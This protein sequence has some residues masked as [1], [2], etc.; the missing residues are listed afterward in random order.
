MGQVSTYGIGPISAPS[1]VDLSG[2][3][4]VTP[5]GPNDPLTEN[6]LGVASNLTVHTPYGEFTVESNDGIPGFFLP[7]LHVSNGQ[8]Y[9]QGFCL[10]DTS[11]P[12]LYLDGQEY[13]TALTAGLSTP[14]HM[15]QPQDIRA[16]FFDLHLAD[17][18]KLSDIDVY[19]PL[20]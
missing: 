16:I 10:G 6:R 1:S 9:A 13:M 2:N 4:L 11:H 19:I 3:L 7:W 17:I 14:T 8:H 15:V 20:S 12:Y 18:K 5:H